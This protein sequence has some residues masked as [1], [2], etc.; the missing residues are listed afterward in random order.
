MRRSETGTGRTSAPSLPPPSATD[1]EYDDDDD[2]T[3]PAVGGALLGTS[4]SD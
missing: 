4:F 3:H 2:V 1:G